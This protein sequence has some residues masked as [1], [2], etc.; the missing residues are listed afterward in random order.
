M[1]KLA[2]QIS[3]KTSEKAGQWRIDLAI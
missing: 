3:E 1:R 2:G